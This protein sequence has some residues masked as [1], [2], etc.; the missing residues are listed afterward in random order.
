MVRARGRGIS[1]G[2]LGRRSVTVRVRRGGERFRPDPRRPRRSLKNLLQE[3]GVPPWCR[4]R[5]PLL[6][7]GGDLVWV[8]GI[9]IDSAYRAGPQEDGLVP[10]WR[11]A[12]TPRAAARRPPPGQSGFAAG[13]G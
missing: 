1:L 12:A 2:R 3:A 13:R 6:F 4:D 11:E 9:G 5:M 8:H 10:V 7:H